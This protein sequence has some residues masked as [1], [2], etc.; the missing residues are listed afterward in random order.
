MLGTDKFKVYRQIFRAFRLTD[1]R[2]GPNLVQVT[3]SRIVSCFVGNKTRT[4]LP[5]LLAR[6]HI[7][8]PT[9]LPAVLLTSLLNTRTSFPTTVD[10]LRDHGD[11]DS[12]TAFKPC[13]VIADLNHAAT[14]PLHICCDP[15]YNTL[16]ICT[17][18]QDYMG[19]LV[20]KW[21]SSSIAALGS[22]RNRLSLPTTALSRICEQCRSSAVLSRR[23]SFRLYCCKHV[24]AVW[25]GISNDIAMLPIWLR[26]PL[27]G[28]LVRLL[29][30]IFYDFDRAYLSRSHRWL[31]AR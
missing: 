16:D 28:R 30:D 31:C 6:F 9:R 21:Y 27:F 12:K 25:Q 29:W 15:T 22:T 2:F 14:I 3:S 11:V 7:F 24:L 10:R 20:N 26:L 19:C 4:Y 18:L 23:L 17:R 8:L 13:S 5:P 1:L